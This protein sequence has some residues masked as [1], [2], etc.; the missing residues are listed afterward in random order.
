MTPRRPS[1]TL[2]PHALAAALLCAGAAAHAQTSSVTLYGTID[3]YV[4]YMKSS[5]GTTLKGVEDGAFLRSRF[6]FR[7]VE[8]LG[9]GL[10]AKFQLESGI[11]A[12]SGASAD[13]TRFFDRQAWV[14]LASPYG[15]FRLG[16]QNGSIFYKGDYID[17]SART[18]GSMVNNF[19]V[20]SRYDNDI[21]YTSPRVA[22]VQVDGHYA[23][24][25]TTA[26]VRSQAVY[27]GSVD[28]LNGPWR[29]GY[30]GL[31]GKPPATAPIQ[32]KVVYDN[33]YGNWDYGQGK[34]Y[35]VYVRSNNVTSSSAGNNAASILSNVGGLVAGTN[36]DAN[37]YYRIVQL[38]ADYR[39]TP[40]L[41]VGGLWGRI[42]DTSGSGRDAS[43]GSI[44]AYYD[45]SKRTTLYTLADT[46]RNNTNAGFRPAGSAG[47][48][49][50]FTNASDVNGRKINGV[51]AGILHRF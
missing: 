33:V 43:G 7:G 12:L 44:G 17:Y 23:L 36:A 34:V 48:P 5:S 20:P 50:N 42:T 10:Q 21:S 27:Q 47:L 29:I 13:S 25:E 1:H 8:D 30:A 28:Y 51:Q 19:G 37:R 11:N 9:G 26:G 16:R 41:R 40:A 2:A 14:G 15:E 39:V 31:R 6:G 45:L 3:Q 32:A 4:N 49:F 46:L 24:A 35:L 18:L 38:S 22:G